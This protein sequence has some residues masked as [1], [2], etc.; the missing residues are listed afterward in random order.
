MEITKKIIADHGGTIEC[1]SK[2]NKTYF[3]LNLPVADVS[4]GIITDYDIHKRLLISED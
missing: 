2:D 4:K 3:N 1:N